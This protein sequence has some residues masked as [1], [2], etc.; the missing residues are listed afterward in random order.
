M[1]G[2]TKGPLVLLFYDGYEWRA[3]ERLIGRLAARAR[4][5]A[6]FIYRML[7]RKQVF[8]GYYASF[9]A[10]RR[11]LESIGCDVRV[12]DFRA[13]RSMP[14]Y[15]IGVCGY[16]SVL[17]AVQLPNPI[18]F[19]PGDIGE[20]SSPETQ[21]G[22]HVLLRDSDW[23]QQLYPAWGEKA[24][25][26][27]SPIDPKA[28]PDQSTQP[29]SVDVLIYDK[30][31]RDR[32]KFVASVL[33]R[34]IAH[35]EKK[36]LSWAV[37][38]YGRHHSSDFK[39]ALRTAKAMAFLSH[40]E[41]QGRAYQEALA[42]GVPVFA[43]NERKFLDP[44]LGKLAPANLQV[45]SVPYFDE[46]CGRQFEV[47]NI[48]R[49]F[50]IFWAAREHYRPRQFIIDRFMPESRAQAYLDFYKRAGAERMSDQASFGPSGPAEP[51]AHGR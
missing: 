4:K 18:V 5:E 8:T 51:I 35:L 48:E 44:T 42:C 15:P 26:W 11:A 40:H 9:L 3:R 45:S 34:L 7:S 14:D 17:A 28:W 10:L 19:G 49:E 23:Q 43:W 20:D 50:D 38:R 36:Q 32:P 33:E 24:A 31:Y 1:I 16:P 27:F 13:A 2:T 12:N 46:R 21:P 6:R 41:T 47:A 37:L 39:S 30:I 25:V 29:K 22:V